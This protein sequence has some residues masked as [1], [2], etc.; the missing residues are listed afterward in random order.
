[1]SGLKI[2]ICVKRDLHGLAVVRQLLPMLGDAQIRIF[3]SVKTRPDEERDPDLKLFK[4]LERDFP[5]D[6]LAPLSSAFTPPAAAPQDWTPLPNLLPNDGGAVLADYAPDVVLSIRFSLIFK[7]WLIER[8]RLGIINIHPGPLPA[9]RGLYT[10]FW[11]ILNSEQTLGCTVHRVDEGIDTGPILG[12]GRLPRDPARSL[13]WHI[14]QIYLS[15]LPIVAAQ[16][17]HL[18]NGGSLGGERQP[19]QGGDYYKFPTRED[20]GRFR[21][22]EG[23]LVTAR[24]YADILSMAYS[25][26]PVR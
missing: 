8:A 10:P 7:P 13:F 9:Y 14:T 24:D 23:Q 5:L 18:R 26:R 11:Q 22:Q 17:D 3:C 1:M 15:G 19:A 20:F 16:V 25:D 4:A 2:A 21:A 12:Y 6:V